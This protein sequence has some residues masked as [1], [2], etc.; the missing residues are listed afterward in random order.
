M[1]LRL[2]ALVFYRAGILTARF[3]WWILYVSLLWL[4]PDTVVCV[5]LI[6]L[7]NDFT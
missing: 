6:V 2:L 7:S 4:L 5:V 1:I 3:R